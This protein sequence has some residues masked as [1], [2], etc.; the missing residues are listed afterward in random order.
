MPS[1]MLF[2]VLPLIIGIFLPLQPVINART[3]EILGHPLW[4]TAVN[5]S[6][7][8]IV[9]LTA[10]AILRIPVPVPAA[11]AAVPWW[12]WLGGVLGASLVTTALLCVPKIGVALTMALLIA[13]QMIASLLLD[14]FNVLPGIDRPVTTLRFLGAI[15]MI[16]GVVLILKF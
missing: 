4:G 15:L 1:T 3:S 10:L 12:G 7:G 11:I 16:A 14:H 8:L 9:A 5:F 2:L 13:G 6:V